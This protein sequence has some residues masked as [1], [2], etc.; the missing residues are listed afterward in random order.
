MSEQKKTSESL[1]AKR[2]PQVTRINQKVVALF[3]GLL[4]IIIVLMVF[5]SFEE[6]TKEV[7]PSPVVQADAAT[8]SEQPDGLSKLPGSYQD[9]QAI[10]AIMTRGNPPSVATA[11]I[12]A[13]MQR[14]L[15]QLHTQQ[16][17]LQ[18]ELMRLRNQ[19]P[20]TDNVQTASLMDREAMTS[21]IFFSG[22][23]PR[24]LT[25]AQNS[26]TE[27]AD[28]NSKEKSQQTMSQKTADNAYQS[29][30]MQGAKL[31]FLKVKPDQNIYNKNT[32]QYPASPYLIQA[33]TVI[34]AILETKVVSNLPGSVIAIVRSNVYD[35]I[36]GQFLLVPKGS[37][38]LGEYSSNV[39]YGQ[40]QIQ[41]K[42]TRLIRPNGTSIVLSS[43]DQ[44]IDDMGVSGLSDEVDNHWGAI[45]GSAVLSAVFN[46]PAIVATNQMNT[47]QSCYTDVNNNTVCTQSLGSIAKG[48]ALQ[49]IGQSASA[50][51]QQV[52]QRSLN[53][54]PTI[55]VNA[56][57]NFSVMV[58]KDM[59]VPPYTSLLNRAS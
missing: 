11:K 42:F 36:T 49:S 20:N 53:L 52:A 45:V 54:Q 46:I 41:L 56:G 48:S 21:A 3:L 19:R 40:D 8:Q 10:K 34:P 1:L 47:S 38:L 15:N 51:G 27:Q 4:L 29:Q 23:A 22:G 37:R 18:A 35:S 17:S 44:G 31:D 26:N 55:I 7:S 16:A 25:N 9:A 33:G 59:I 43:G 13:E 39:S 12:P 32:I 58:T 50:V 5:S 28:K 30:N 57:Y 24:P 2:I 6:K 14:E